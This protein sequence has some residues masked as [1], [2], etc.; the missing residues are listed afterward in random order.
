MVARRRRGG[1]LELRSK[2]RQSRSKSKVQP[3]AE[4]GAGA[5]GKAARF[6]FGWPILDR[7]GLARRGQAAIPT[8]GEITRPAGTSAN[9]Q[10]S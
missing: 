9:A 1:S 7:A 2:S 6:E 10:L 4:I 5:I 8:I 3:C